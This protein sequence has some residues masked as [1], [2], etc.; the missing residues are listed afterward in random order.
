MSLLKGKSPEI[1]EKFGALFVAD[2]RWKSYVEKE[3]SL[4]AVLAGKEASSVGE[5]VSSAIY[6]PQ[7]SYGKKVPS[8]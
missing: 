2:E 3:K 8:R 6:N 4:R 7:A 5:Q 1:V